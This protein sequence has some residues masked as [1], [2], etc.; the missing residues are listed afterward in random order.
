MPGKVFIPRS[1]TVS[2][3]LASVRWIAKPIRS[4]SKVSSVTSHPSN[5]TCVPA[6]ASTARP[7]SCTFFRMAVP[8][9]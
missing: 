2:P 6:T 5:T 7:L 3:S 8:S 1:Q 9:K 4:V